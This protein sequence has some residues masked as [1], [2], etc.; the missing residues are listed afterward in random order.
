MF[1]GSETIIEISKSFNIPLPTNVLVTL[2]APIAPTGPCDPE[3][4][5]EPVKPYDPV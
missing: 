2:G 5:I 4:P 1:D 3:N